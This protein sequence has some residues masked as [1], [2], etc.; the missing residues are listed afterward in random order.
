[1]I[2]RSKD[3]YAELDQLGLTEAEPAEPVPVATEVSP[4][5]FL[6][7]VYRNAGFPMSIRLRAAQSAAQYMHP[8]ISVVATPGGNIAERLER[9][10]WNNASGRSSS[11]RSQFNSNTFG[12]ASNTWRRV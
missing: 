7:A 12:A 8:R 5:D 4:L 2:N 1:M 6:C 11:R 9:L 3:I 10:I